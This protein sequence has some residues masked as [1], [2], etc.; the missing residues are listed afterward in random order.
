[1]FLSNLF[2][3][4]ITKIY[5][6]LAVLQEQNLKIISLLQKQE[7][8]NSVMTFLPENIP[9]ALPMSTPDTVQT[10]DEFLNTIEN[11]NSLVR[12]HTE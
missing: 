4:V 9:V 1:M 12:V 5:T 8:A 7:P 6:G 3:D 11:S 2:V 10:L